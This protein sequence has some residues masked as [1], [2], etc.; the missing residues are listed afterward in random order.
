MDE[1]DQEPECPDS[2]DGQHNWVKR[3]QKVR[4]WGGA[5]VDRY[6]ECTECGEEKSD[7]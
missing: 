2:Q 5:D 3:A 1:E 4:T 7:G 6:Y